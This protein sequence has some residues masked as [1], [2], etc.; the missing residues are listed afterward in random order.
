MTKSELYRILDIDDPSEFIYYDNH[1]ALLEEET[2]IEPELISDILVSVEA[3]LLLDMSNTYFD[4]FLKSI[5][6]E[7]ADLYML[8][9]NMKKVF[10]GLIGKEI[11]EDSAI[12]L[13]DE[14]V[15]FRKWY[16]LDQLAY[17]RNSGKEVSVRDARFDI[18]AA[19][20]TDEKFDYDFENA[21]DYEIEGYDVS[22]A[23]MLLD[24]LDDIDFEEV[25]YEEFDYES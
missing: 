9:E 10:I 24:E 19:K 14:I 12:I 4:D 13:A 23:D 1:A 20:Y 5:P 17:E 15:K 3:D 16:T 2:Y 11:N 25:N 7:E 18:L 8:V 21:L 6:D 22:V